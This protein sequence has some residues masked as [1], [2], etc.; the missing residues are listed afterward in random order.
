MLRWIVA[1][2]LVRAQLLFI[3]GV[4]NE[5]FRFFSEFRLINFDSFRQFE[6]ENFIIIS[7]VALEVVCEM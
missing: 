7:R 1:T 6:M 4:K 5:T 2:S 3:Y